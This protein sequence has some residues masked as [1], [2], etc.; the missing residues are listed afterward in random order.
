MPAT[1]TARSLGRKRRSHAPPVADATP[2][3]DAGLR[4][5]A[6]VLRRKEF[7]DRIRLH[8]AGGYEKLFREFT[9]LHFEIFWDSNGRVSG[10]ANRIPAGCAARPGERGACRWLQ[11]ANGGGDSAQPHPRDRVFT[12][13]RGL[14]NFWHSIQIEGISLG[15]AVLQALNPEPAGKKPSRPQVAASLVAAA[16]GAR[17]DR[18]AALLRLVIHDAVA[19]TLADI[20]SRELARARQESASHEREAQKAREQLQ[21]IHPQMPGA[22]QEAGNGSGAQD[23]VSL[24]LD[25][26]HASYSRPMSLKDFATEHEMNAAYLSNVFSMNVGVPFKR[27]LT[28]F[29]MEKARELLRDHGKQISDVAAAVGYSNASLF[30]ATFKAA[31]GVSPARF[32][33]DER[34]G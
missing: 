4:V 12:C 13:C 26:V 17:F 16:D 23:F 7:Q 29:R 2:G 34:F 1:K 8:L 31:A 27:Y 6:T 28:D 19:A 10:G 18:A 9:G 20:R 33:K 11:H 21:R 3:L 14:R 24:M 32:R 15:V 25:F 30:S 22:A 5:S